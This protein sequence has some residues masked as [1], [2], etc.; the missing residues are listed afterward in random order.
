MAD[1]TTPTSWADFAPRSNDPGGTELSIPPI[2]LDSSSVHTPFFLSNTPNSISTVAPFV[3]TLQMSQFEQ[4]NSASAIGSSASSHYASYGGTETER[5]RNRTRNSPYERER[6]GWKHRPVGGGE[7]GSFRSR[8]HGARYPNYEVNVEGSTSSSTKPNARPPRPSPN[9]ANNHA[10]THKDQSIIPTNKRLSQNTSNAIEHPRPAIDRSHPA[11]YATTIY[12]AETQHNH[13]SHHQ[14][15]RSKPI[16]PAKMTKSAHAE[17]L[18]PNEGLTGVKTTA[19]HHNEV[20]KVLSTGN[21]H[22]RGLWPSP[23]RGRGWARRGGQL[24]TGGPPL[25]SHT[26]SLATPILPPMPHHHLPPDALNKALNSSNLVSQKRKLVGASSGPVASS[27]EPRARGSGPVSGRDFTHLL[28]IT[29]RQKIQEQNQDAQMPV[30]SKNEIGTGNNNSEQMDELPSKNHDASVDEPDQMPKVHYI[31][32]SRIES[33]ANERQPSPSPPLPRTF[34]TPPVSPPSTIAPM[35]NS[36]SSSTLINS[37]VDAVTTTTTAIKDEP[38]DLDIP[39]SDTPDFS[40]DSGT[41]R[42]YPVPP[43]C[44]KFYSIN[45]NADLPSQRTSSER[46]FPNPHVQTARAEYSRRAVEELRVNGV[47]AKGFSGVRMAC[48]WTGKKRN[49]H[50][51]ETQVAREHREDRI[52]NRILPE[53]TR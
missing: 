2:F 39:Y 30:L 21:R 40:K 4:Q 17:D 28:P 10:S 50:R 51:I 49:L 8:G 47:V 44:H 18:Q 45:T 48:V 33:V 5:H 23:K 12:E 42:Y 7:E 25:N 29:K 41:K 34:P 43:S 52:G 35:E 15:A 22:G 9:N 1:A 46:L 53:T 16:H 19:A 26:K 38:L 11:N 37:A 36:G 14:P 32:G 3:N 20:P 13:H 24:R 27:S 31:S 6:H